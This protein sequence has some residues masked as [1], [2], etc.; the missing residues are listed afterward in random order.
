MKAVKKMLNILFALFMI[1]SSIRTI[2]NIINYKKP[3]GK[4]TVFNKEFI[5][6][7][8]NMADSYVIFIKNRNNIYTYTVYDIEYD[9]EYKINDSVTF[10]NLHNGGGVLVLTKNNITMNDYYEMYDYIM[11]FLFIF[12]PLCYYLLNYKLKIK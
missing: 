6:G 5:I 2:P 11:F 3:I 4:G 1:V 10:R 7:G 8:I 9:I 12:L